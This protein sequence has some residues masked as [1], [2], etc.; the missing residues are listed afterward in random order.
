M[1]IR[2]NGNIDLYEHGI[3]FKSLDI[4]LTDDNEH[5]YCACND[6]VDFSELVVLDE[7]LDEMIEDYVE[8]IEC[9]DID[10]REALIAM[11]YEILGL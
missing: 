10:I 11:I 6:E 4:E 1:K 2:L 9:T 3:S 8:I 7:Y 5:A